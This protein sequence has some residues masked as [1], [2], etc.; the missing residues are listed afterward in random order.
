MSRHGASGQGQSKTWQCRDPTRAF[1]NFLFRPACRECGSRAPQ[2]VI[3]Q[4]REQ[5]QQITSGGNGKA[6]RGNAW[7]NGPP[8]LQSQGGSRAGGRANANA[9]ELSG[10]DIIKLLESRGLQAGSDIDTKLT[11]VLKKAEEPG[12]ADLGSK[13]LQ[14]LLQRQS[15]KLKQIEGSTERVQNA[16]AALEEAQRYYEQECQQLKTEPPEQDGE[17]DPKHELQMLEVLELAVK[18]CTSRFSIDATAVLAATEAKKAEFTSKLPK[19]HPVWFFGRSIPARG[20]L[21]RPCWSGR[22]MV[23]KVDQ[24]SL[25]FSVS[26]S[27]LLC[28]EHLLKLERISGR[29][30]L[31]RSTHLAFSKPVKSGFDMLK[32]IFWIFTIFKDGVGNHALADQT[33]FEFSMWSLRGAG[34]DQDARLI[35]GNAMADKWAKV[36]KTPM[37]ST[38]ALLLQQVVLGFFEGIVLSGAMEAQMADVKAQALEEFSAMAIETLPQEPPAA[39][40]KAAGPLF[41]KLEKKWKDSVKRLQGARISG[42]EGHTQP[43][44]QRLAHLENEL[45]LAKARPNEAPVASS[46]WDRVVDHSILVARSPDQVLKAKVGSR[47]SPFFISAD[48]NR[49]DI[50]TEMACKRLR[51]ALLHNGMGIVTFID[52][53]G[54]P[55]SLD[56][57]T[58]GEYYAECI[59]E[60]TGGRVGDGIWMGIFCE[61]TEFAFDQPTRWR[62]GTH[63]SGFWQGVPGR[64]P[65]ALEGSGCGR[66]L[67]LGRRAGRDQRRGRKRGRPP[68]DG[69]RQRAGGSCWDVV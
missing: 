48:R 24:A 69:D 66:P 31:D 7:L 53:R 21:R 57:G 23:M 41:G 32:P 30:R 5:R 37:V 2:R 10:E 43:L 68:P 52:R 3:N 13:G 17:S 40:G 55:A 42:L 58:I 15:R 61:M 19:V 51:R 34:S 11:E 47:S 44:E 20:Q 60:N 50:A 6:Q 26:R 29:G 49:Q 1:A 12:P 35:K 28:A 46:D 33:G 25:T 38:L 18:K 54:W 56:M 4:Q 64:D 59:D 67:L 16:K 39:L 36:R 45:D 14:D 9:T 63:V 62:E 22:N 27:H 8:V 65:I